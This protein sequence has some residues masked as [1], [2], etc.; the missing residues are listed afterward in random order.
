M[1]IAGLVFHQHMLSS[2]VG[3]GQ[4]H[5]VDVLNESIDWYFKEISALDICWNN[6]KGITSKTDKAIRNGCLHSMIQE[7]KMEDVH[8]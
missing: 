3:N 2:G 5:G 1:K 8:I 6:H 7:I 4:G